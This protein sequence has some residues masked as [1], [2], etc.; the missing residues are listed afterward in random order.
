MA[1]STPDRT[2]SGQGR[3][4]L[5]IALDALIVAARQDNH[6]YSAEYAAVRKAAREMGEG[7]AIEEVRRAGTL[8]LG[9]VDLPIVV[10]NGLASPGDRVWVVRVEEGA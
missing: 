9:D 6:D 4:A 2:D 3:D 8:S 1:E 10:L 7:G 5:D